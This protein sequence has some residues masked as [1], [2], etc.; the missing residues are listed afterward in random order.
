MLD[1]LDSSEPELNSEDVG[2]LIEDYLKKNDFR[3]LVVSQYSYMYGILIIIE[4]IGTGDYPE[5]TKEIEKISNL[6]SFLFDKLDIGKT[7]LR[8]IMGQK[9]LLGNRGTRS[10]FISV[11]P[12]IFS[13][14]TGIPAPEI[15]KPKTKEEFLKSIEDIYSGDS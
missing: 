3:Y 10:S 7:S 8:F 5:R 14:L 6:A 13:E 12:V 11:D 2:R 15:F 1:H 4:D 9:M